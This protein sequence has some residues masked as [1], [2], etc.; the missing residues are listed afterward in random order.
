MWT[1][2]GISKGHGDSEGRTDEYS[3]INGFK[4]NSERGVEKDKYGRRR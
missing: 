1:G 2:W 3:D 4:G